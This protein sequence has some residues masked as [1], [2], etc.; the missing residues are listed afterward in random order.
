MSFPQN[1]EETIALFKL[2]QYQL[3]WR[4]AHLQ[5]RFPDAVIENESGQQLV[6]EFEYLSRNFKD[7]EHDPNGCDLIICWKDNWKNPPVPVWALRD[8]A[9]EEALW[10]DSVISLRVRKIASTMYG[11]LRPFLRAEELK[12]IQPVPATPGEE[13]WWHYSLLQNLPK[14]W[15]W[16]LA[17]ATPPNWRD[18]IRSKEKP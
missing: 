6:V 9:K 8:C 16:A 17:L 13:F 14:G 5:T 15:H 10:L 11:R 4:I 2:V 12:E 18:H 3:G 1:E 7:H